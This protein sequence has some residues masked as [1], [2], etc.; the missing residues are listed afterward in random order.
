MPGNIH[1]KKSSYIPSIPFFLKNDCRDGE[2]NLPTINKKVLVLGAG[3][4]GLAAAWHLNRIG[5]DVTVYECAGSIGGHANTING[6][7]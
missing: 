3:C 4:A 1:R 2:A 7:Y 6:L 5:I